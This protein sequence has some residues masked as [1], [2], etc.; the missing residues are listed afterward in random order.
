MDL[1]YLLFLQ[2][3]VR[4]ESLTPFMMGIS[5]FAISFWLMSAVF[6]V[7]WSIDK[8]SGLFMIASYCITSFLN[9]LVKLSFCIYRPW[10]RDP[11]V[12]PVTVGGTSAKATAG[13]Y[14]FPSG[15]TQIITASLGSGAVLTWLKRRWLSILF[16]I[17]ILLVAFSRNYLGVHTPQDVVVGFILGFLSVY[18]A[19][20]FVN[21]ANQDFKSDLKILIYFILTCISAILY[22]TY[23]NYPMTLDAEGKLLV[24]PLRMMRDGFLSTG[25]WLGFILG[26]FIEKYCIK[27]STDCSIFNKILRSVFGVITLYLVYYKIGSL[28]YKEMS[29]SWARF[30]QWFL[31]IF[32]VMVI[33]P[34][35][36]KFIESLFQ[37]KNHTKQ[38]ENKI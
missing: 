3:N 37:N 14:S 26:W 33:Y 32:Y 16:L 34:M 28:F 12:M 10:I 18:W 31:M 13:G 30:C 7:F 38:K 4:T 2:N 24:D 8:K 23:K 36:F 15:H 20:L 9:S 5:N 19:Y 25:L 11:N 27:F 17:I 6:C 1:Q 35:I 22:Y 21:R 29:V